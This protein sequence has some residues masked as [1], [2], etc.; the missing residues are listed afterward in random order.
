[1]LIFICIFS[2]ILFTIINQA[3]KRDSPLAVDISTAIL[4]LSENGE[5]Q[6]IHEKWFCKMGCPGERRQKTESN[7]LHMISFWGL[8]LLCGVFTLGALL[9][10]LLRM[11][12]QFA[13]YKRQQRQQPQQTDPSSP[14]TVLSKA[15]CPQI[16]YSFFDFIDEKEEAIKKMFTQGDN[17]PGRID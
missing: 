7:Q 9:V 6:K 5:L 10:F 11:V 15:H 3:F 4:K 1:M 8:Y 14:S 17:P 12:C 13:R 2:L 16:I